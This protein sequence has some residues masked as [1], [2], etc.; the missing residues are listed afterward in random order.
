MAAPL[1]AAHRHDD[2]DNA[3]PKSKSQVTCRVS[4]TT[5]MGMCNR[6]PNMILRTRGMDG[7][8][9]GNGGKLRNDGGLRMVVDDNS[10]NDDE[11]D[12]ES[13]AS[14]DEHLEQVPTANFST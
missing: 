5:C 8:I 2:H 9:V 6:S 3:Q 11:S 14:R 7:G 1:V 13:D 10:N 12:D 4:L